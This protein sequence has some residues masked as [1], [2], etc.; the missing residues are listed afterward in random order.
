MH[1]ISHPF[2]HSFIRSHEV[3]MYVY[4]YVCLGVCSLCMY[5]ARMSVCIYV[6]TVVC[7]YACSY[8]YVCLCRFPLRRPAYV[9]VCMYVCMYVCM[10]MPGLVL[11]C[12]LHQ[13]S[14]RQTNSKAISWRQKF[15]QTAFRYPV[16]FGGALLM[17]GR[18]LGPGRAFKNAPNK[19]GQTSKM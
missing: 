16:F 14:A 7:M 1:W 17:S 5:D 11:Q 10:C 12:R 9:F 18:P 19:S 15:G 4:K 13:K 2:I 8:V 6:C 3:H